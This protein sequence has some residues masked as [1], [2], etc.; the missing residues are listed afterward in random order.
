VVRDDQ[1][2]GSHASLGP[3]HEVHETNLTV[4]LAGDFERVYTEG[5]NAPVI[6]TDTIRNTVY[7]LAKQH[8]YAAPETLGRI[9]ASYFLSEFD[10]VSGCRVELAK[11]RWSRIPIEGADHPHAFTKQRGVRTARAESGS[12]LQTP[13]RGPRLC[14]G[15]S[16]L[17]VLKTT[18]SA[19]EGFMRDRY[20]TLPETDDRILAT[21]LELEWDYHEGGTDLEDERFEELFEVALGAALETFAVHESPSIQATTYRIGEEILARAPE[22]AQVHVTAPNQHHVLFDLDR[23]GME[24]RN[25]IFVSTR[26]PYGIIRGSIAR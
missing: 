16:G 17:E 24:N 18:G 22:I 23:F 15:I 25:E 26:E 5:D 11:E 10:H 20:T 6:A 9:I 3:W 8:D 13:G 19:F 2:G 1:A 7:A 4:L 21:T 14:G 12:F